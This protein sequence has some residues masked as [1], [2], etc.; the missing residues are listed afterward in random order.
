VT[1][2]IGLD[3]SAVPARPAGAGRY[4][5]ELAKQLDANQEI[6]LTAITRRDD[7]DR[8]SSMLPNSERL[9][10]VPNSR[11]MRLFYEQLRLGGRVDHVGL[12]LYHGP[13]YS[14]PARLSTPMVATIHD[15][16]FFD[17]PDVHERAKVMYF[18]GAI[19]HAATHAEGVIC[20]S[21]RTARR[22]GELLD[23]VGD[24]TVA[25][26]GIDHGRFTPQ[27]SV[28]ED[29]SLLDS[30]GVDGN[31]PLV[32]C[33]GT[34]EPRK[35]LTTLLDAFEALALRHQSVELVMAGQRGWNLGEFDARLARSAARDRIHVL[36]YVDDAVVPALYRR[37]KV[38]AYPSIDEGFGLPVVEA[39]ACGAVVVTTQDS[40][41]ADLAGT[42]ASYVPA[43]DAAALSR[44]MSETL[45]LDPTVRAE[46]AQL[47]QARAKRYT[48]AGCAQATLGAYDKAIAR[49][50]QARPSR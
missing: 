8:W 23:V 16:T 4:C 9:S 6:S 43:L 19:K 40:V 47:A 27:A 1:F 41:M 34:L 12:D 30:V 14:L 15:L 26:L 33:V 3:L 36:G 25:E 31:R 21:E 17:H 13:H 5:V 46:I 32:V 38:V 22:L 18:R 44:A 35:G 20:D 29:L 24:V 39:L 2:R 10:I 48:W 45:E 42:T 7:Q 11:P 50:G 28:Q 37:A 49:K